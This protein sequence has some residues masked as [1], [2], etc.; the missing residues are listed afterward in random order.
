MR[1]FAG[2]AEGEGTD[3][4]TRM[5]TGGVF[6][7]IF[8]FSL[9][10]II[11][12]LFLQLYVTVD[13]IIVGRFLGPQS[14][15]AVSV[16]SPI[17]FVVV[18]FLYG[19]CTGISVLI[20]RE[21]GSG[22]RRRLHEAAA[23][24]L[25]FGVVFTLALTAV[26][27][28]GARSVLVWTKAPA[29]LHDET[30]QYL[31]IVFVGLI[32]SFLYNYFASAL[33]GIGNSRVP[34]V[35]QVIASCLHI[36]M[37]LFFVGSCGLGVRG[38]ALATVLSQ[39]VSSA[40]CVIYIYRREPVLAVGRGDFHVTRAAL[41]AT[42][43]YSWAAALQSIIVYVGRFLTQGC[44]N[45]LGA[46]TVAG[47]NAATRLENIVMMAYDGVGVALATFVAQNLGARHAERVRGGLRTSIV[48][49]LVYV[50]VASSAV[51][52]FAPQ[53]MSMFVSGSGGEAVINAGVI[54][55]RPM[56]VYMMLSSV[57]AM[58][59]SFFRGL[60]EFRTVMLV[61]LSQIALRVALSFW[62]V[63]KWGVPAIA[64]STA[65]G[66]VL[67]FFILVALIRSHMRLITASCR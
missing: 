43:N 44:V 24:S 37:N 58:M 13:A 45:P 15:A 3:P 38:S 39:V 31:N 40:A 49:V 19:G 57:D 32:F 46:N 9:P 7:S 22:D 2:A 33:R 27:L 53:I 1:L 20:A 14:L 55:L 66:W 21:F 63:P 41:A 16:A 59:Q 34:F 6:S 42:I 18:F 62:L 28:A 52:I 35:F 61:S 56:C 50:A 30:M 12:N 5:L 26:C 54:Y 23:T 4:K 51:F 65:V 67:I 47:Y 36:A 17:L 48:M 11:G 64:H 25:I 60:G 10:I 8:L 29:E